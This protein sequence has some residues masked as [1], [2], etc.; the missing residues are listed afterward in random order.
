VFYA[1]AGLVLLNRGNQES[2]GAFAW[3]RRGICL[4]PAGICFLLTVIYH[5]TPEHAV[6]VN[7]SWISLWKTIDPGNPT[8]G[9]PDASIEALGWTTEQGLSL[10]L[11]MLGSGFYQPLA[12][13]MVF[14]ISF[15]LVVLF[16]DR[17]NDLEGQPAMTTR[18]RVTAL[19]LQQLVFISP[20]FLLGVDYGRWLFLW[21]VSS[22][23]LHTYGGR[24]SAWLESI[25]VRIFDFARIPQFI[26]KVPARD[27]Y[28]LFFGVPV[29]WNLHSFL[30]ASPLGRH[31]DIIRSWL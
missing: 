23:M 31:L 10:S 5:G 11:Y 19:L 25:V 21:L 29:C 14:T 7:D 15:I 12:W 3:L 2:P 27:W 4:L 22:M 24:A 8:V 28:L 1:L 20:L 13:L 9:T 6:A 17:D 16:T 30:T 26:A 18:I